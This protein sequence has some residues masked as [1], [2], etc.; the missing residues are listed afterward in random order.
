MDV[1]T[2]ITLSRDQTGTPAGQIADGDYLTYLNVV[3]KEIF[4]RLAV[5][6]KKYARQ[7]F[8]TEVHAGQS[9]YILPQPG[10]DSTGLKLVLA[11]FLD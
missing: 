9:E 1:S 2:I 11:A 7:S 5:N 10:E 6:S 3:Y 8:D 4:S